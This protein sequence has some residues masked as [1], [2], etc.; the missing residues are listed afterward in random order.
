MA[1]MTRAEL[2]KLIREMV[3]LEEMSVHNPTAY[4]DPTA[5]DPY[6]E[7]DPSAAD[8]GVEAMA[9][10]EAEMARLKA[11]RKRQAAADDAARP[12]ATEPV[13]GISPV[14]DRFNDPAYWGRPT[15]F[16]R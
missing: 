5:Y 13:A 10:R 16:Y 1:K 11:N 12:K 4:Y 15:S 8:Q 14:D 3:S 9:A 6:D 7:N 2:R